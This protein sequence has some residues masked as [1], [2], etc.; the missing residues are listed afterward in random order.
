[1][2]ALEKAENID[3]RASRVSRAY[4]GRSGVFVFLVSFLCLYYLQ[5]SLIMLGHYDLGWHLAAGDLIRLRG[6]VPFQDPW[7]FTLEN[8]QWYNLSWLWDV[9]ASIVYQYS[10]LTGLLLFTLACGAAIAAYLISVCYSCGASTASICLSVF[11]ACLL[12]PS[13][14][15]PPNVYLA[16][17]PNTF[18][19]LFCVVFFGE[20]LKRSRCYVLPMLMLAWVNLHGGFLLGFLIIGVFGATALV[21]LDW[22]AAKTYFLTGLACAATIIVNPLGWNIVDGLRATLGH[23]VQAN[24]TEWQ[25]YY[26]NMTMPASVPGILYVLLFAVL[27]LRRNSPR[28]IPLETRILSWLFLCLGIY[29]FRYMSVFFLFS[30]V[31]VALHL[32]PLLRN[33]FSEVDLQKALLAAGAVVTCVLPLVFFRMQPA[34]ALPEMLSQ[35]DADYLQAHF[36]NARLLNHWNVG[37]LLIFRTK[38]AVPVFVDGRAATAY[39][40]GLLRDYFSLIHEEIDERA[41]DSVLAKYRI[42]AVLW[43]KAHQQLR[44]FLVGK[45]GWKEEYT[46]TYETIYVKP[47]AQ[48]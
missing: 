10:Q 5:N 48:P 1:M 39:P 2:A 4:L 26:L 27:E 44:E 43:V 16:V 32:D 19:M 34:L 33:R 9:G 42:D 14:G 22:N 41:W 6:D 11:A 25:S 35:Q 37:G 30:A 46:G 13:F 12:Y 17:A 7:S 21:R 47:Q 38:G 18:T 23:F 28:S 20:C 36:S 3:A 24:I 40:D 45:R 29:Q 8:R 31:P 15:T